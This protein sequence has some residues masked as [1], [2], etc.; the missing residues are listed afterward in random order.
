LQNQTL[1]HALLAPNGLIVDTNVPE[2]EARCR[3]AGGVEGLVLRVERLTTE[4]DLTA[5]MPEWHEL[6]VSLS[7]R[8]P[9]TSPVWKLL[10]WKHFKR[11]KLASRDRLN[12]YAVRDLL[13][14]LV[15]VAPMMITYRPSIGPLRMRELQF[16]GADS[17]V[18]ELRGI[19]CRPENFSQVMVALNRVMVR[20]KRAWDWVQWRGLRATSEMPVW[21]EQLPNFKPVRT[22][23]DHYL[24]LPDNWDKFK[25]GL[26]RNLK[27]SLRKC[28]NSLAR[29][30]HTFVF[31]AISLPAEIPAAIDRFLALHTQ[32]ATMS[33]TVDHPNIFVQPQ[34]QAFLRDYAASM[35]ERGDIRVFEL[36]I[37][38]AVVATRI[39][40]LFGDEMYLFYSGYNQ[41]W[42]R[43]SVMT[44]VVAEALKWG[45][46]NGIKI[47]N[48][49]TG[50]DVS[51]TRWRPDHIAYVE[52]F[53]VAPTYRGAIAFKL[54]SRLRGLAKPT[55]NE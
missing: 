54:M 35:A 23:L 47:A 48:L 15:A 39:A 41:Q 1:S 11:D 32:R 12:T 3:T 28:Y 7:P 19:V 21:Q 24:R 49:S 16:L 37:D 10:W 45:I 30:G 13:G 9:F 55:P 53:Q 51:K 31:R 27:E 26:P 6:D 42:S 2:M 43:Y 40:F 46:A 52:G 14:R 33:G 29:D 38:G 18:T 4:Q 5:L 22:V 17:N 36:V 20:D 25:A 50:T 34:A 8:I 44:T